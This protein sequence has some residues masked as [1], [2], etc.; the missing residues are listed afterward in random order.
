[1]TA[2]LASILKDIRS[3]RPKIVE[4]DHIR[5]L[6]VTKWFLDFFLTLREIAKQP[7]ST[8]SLATWGFGLVAEVTER[9]WIVWVLRRMRGA[10]E[11]KV[12]SFAILDHPV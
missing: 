10:V 12:C 9:Q 4:K 2:F 1:V 11:E 5:L 6:Y 8:E 3:E 7:N